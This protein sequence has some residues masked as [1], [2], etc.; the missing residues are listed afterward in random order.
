MRIRM[1]WRSAAFDWNRAR[2]FLATAEEGSLSAAAA[3]LG[4]TQPTLGRQVAALEEELGVALFER[5]G[6]GL[7]LTPSG[8]ALL[9][10]ARAMRS[11]ANSLSLAASGQA[12]GLD[13]AISI[14]ASETFAA[15]LLP[16]ATARIRASHPN[17]RVDLVAADEVRDL[18]RREADIAVRHVR[19]TEPDLVCRKIADAQARLYASREYLASTGPF[20]DAD[21]L[22]KADFI[23]FDRNS[24]LVQGLASFGVQID[25]SR[26]VAG[27]NSHHAHWALVRQGLGVGVMETGVAESEGD[28]VCAAPWAPPF[29]FP[30]WLV[31]H[32]E[33]HTSRRVRV[34]FDIL[35][36]FLSERAASLRGPNKSAKTDAPVQRPERAASA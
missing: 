27:S 36:E 28:V 8:E 32:R 11:A 1:D 4:L 24:E 29:E 14:T 10:H 30:V 25:E 13:G 18:L 6:R 34:A 21:A 2:A 3:T 20:P 26:F 23:G 9:A 35:A 16:E 5:V 12:E 22:S 15:R 31:V 19:P 33:V 7:K 17:L